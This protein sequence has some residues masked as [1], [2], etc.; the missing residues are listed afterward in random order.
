MEDLDLSLFIIYLY[1]YAALTISEFIPVLIVILENDCVVSPGEQRAVVSD[2]RLVCVCQRHP[3]CAQ[4][5]GLRAFLHQVSHPDP[6]SVHSPSHADSLH[7]SARYL[8][9]E[10]KS[11][12]IVSFLVVDSKHF[13][14]ISRSS[15]VKKTADYG[16]MNHNP[17][18]PGQSSP[19][20]IPRIN[21]NI[22]HNNI[23]FIGPQLPP[24]MTK[25][26]PVALN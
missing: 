2:E 18:I 3:L 21:T 20:P 9:F 8:S 23:G 14:F 22:H 1:I 6:E 26:R 15:D 12:Q 11:E 13:I 19:R 25:V 16:H 17:G 7:V 10:D 4:P 5:A 24:H